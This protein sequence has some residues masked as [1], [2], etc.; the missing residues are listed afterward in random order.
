MKFFKYQG[1]GNDFILI[2]NRSLFFDT[3][4]TSLIQRLCNRRY[5]IGSDG[6][7]LIQ[8]HPDYD[9]EIHFF[10]PDGSLSMCGNGS[11]CAVKYAQQCQI[12]E[13]HTHFLAYDG[14]HWAFIDTSGLVHL[15]MCDV[16][17]ID[18]MDKDYFVNTGAPHY[19]QQVSDLNNLDITTLGRSIRNDLRFQDLGT[20]VNFFSIDSDFCVSVRTYEKG[21]EDETLSCGTGA[22]AVSLVLSKLGMTSPT[23]IHTRGGQLIVTYNKSFEESFNEI[24]LIGSS[25]CVFEGTIDIDN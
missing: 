22:V 21:V 20:N 8:N 25:E 19:V 5:G 6:L 23:T 1:S 14:A 24:Y 12:I 10:N 11:R 18:K 15:K 2:D 7:I 9:F 17:H 4:N 16:F 3:K 13:L